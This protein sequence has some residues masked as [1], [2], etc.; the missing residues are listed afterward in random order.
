[1]WE[2]GCR[3]AVC[4]GQ[5]SPAALP[6][7][8]GVSPSPAD[9]SLLGCEHGR[10]GDRPWAPS[11]WGRAVG[12][13][14]PVTGA[15]GGG[16]WRSTAHVGPVGRRWGAQ[17][18]PDRALG[19]PRS[20]PSGPVGEAQL[21]LVAL[22]SGF[23]PTP[24]GCRGDGRAFLPPPPRAAGATGQESR[25]SGGLESWPHPGLRA[26]PGDPSHLEGAPGGCVGPGLAPPP[27][28]CVWPAEPLSAASVPWPA[29]PASLLGAGGSRAAQEG[30]CLFPFTK[31]NPR[32]GWWCG[33]HPILQDP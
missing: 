12:P 11:S 6:S 32:D 8:P 7:D 13:G 10:A 31:I 33:R 22:G 18:S 26:R 29:P 25:G 1:M 21:L 17:G 9:P 15:G 3:A 20:P 4:L 28:A 30:P 2:A 23:R 27:R 16:G 19:E 14:W 24:T 5:A